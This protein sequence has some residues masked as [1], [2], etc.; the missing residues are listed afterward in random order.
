M[1]PNSVYRKY[2]EAE[3]AGYEKYSGV[4]TFRNG[5]V[6]NG[7]LNFDEG[8]MWFGAIDGAG[9]EYE[10]EEAPAIYIGQVDP[11]TGESIDENGHGWKLLGFGPDDCACSFCGEKL[12]GGWVNMA[13]GEAFCPHHIDYR[14]GQ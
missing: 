13:T 12:S 6:P 4:M 8:R 7:L 9:R 2:S 3:C 5:D 10:T 1:I 14:R 11:A